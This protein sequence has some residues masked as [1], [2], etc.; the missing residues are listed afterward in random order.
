E[1]RMWGVLAVHS[2]KSLPKDSELRM[3]QFSNLVATAIGNADARREVTRLANEQA[4]L[5][6]IA[7]LVARGVEPDQVFAAV[8]EETA[9][10]F[11]AIT[12]VMRF[13]HDPPGNV[14]VG[15][16]KET[17]IPIGTRWPLGEGM[18]SA[19]VYRTGRSARLG[20]VDWASRP[21]PVAEAGLRFGVTSQVACPIIVQG[22][23]WG[24]VTLNAAEELPPDTE[25]RLEKFT[26][27]VTTA[28][29]NAEAGVALRTVADEQ[30]A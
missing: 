11:H 2:R 9:T 27:L 17:G 14:I 1:S 22:S 8:T 18:T 19:E 6:R 25:Q 13:E 20:G 21:G 4:A 30:G 5:R 23:V 28:I 16:S 7:T 26:E 3:E 24:V 15:V 12:A 29:A 10:T